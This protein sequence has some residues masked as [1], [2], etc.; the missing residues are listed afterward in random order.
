MKQLHLVVVNGLPVLILYLVLIIAVL[1]VVEM[2]PVR[3]DTLT[4]PRAEAMVEPVQ[5]YQPLT[6]AVPQRNITHQQ[7]APPAPTHQ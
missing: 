6:N 1:I 7:F 3:A 2:Q 5:Q 4:Q